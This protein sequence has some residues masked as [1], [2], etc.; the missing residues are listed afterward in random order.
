MAILDIQKLSEL[1]KK[2]SH[3][4]IVLNALTE[5]VCQVFS[6]PE[7]NLPGNLRTSYV[8][9]AETLKSLNVLK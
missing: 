1:E 8:L 3:N 7:G 6:E 9:S 4:P 2:Y 5:M